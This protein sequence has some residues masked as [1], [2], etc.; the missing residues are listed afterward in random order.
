MRKEKQ[1]ACYHLCFT[2]CR[3]VNVADRRLRCGS[4]GEV[5]TI[6]FEERSEQRLSLRK[7]S[8]ARKY[9]AV[10]ANSRKSRAKTSC[11]AKSRFCPMIHKITGHF[12]RFGGSNLGLF[13]LLVFR[14]LC[15]LVWWRGR[16]ST[17]YSTRFS[18]LD[19]RFEKNTYTCAAV[20][21]KLRGQRR[22]WVY[23]IRTLGRRR[24]RCAR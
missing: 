17:F 5:N 3:F 2:M 22:W 19:Q 15:S 1:R 21:Q 8:S 13:I 10:R 18:F 14:V 23:S 16:S 9:W 24:P 12:F 7:E 20:P 11:G 6:K 4:G